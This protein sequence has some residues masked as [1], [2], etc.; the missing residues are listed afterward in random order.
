MSSQLS[1]QTIAFARPWITD[2]DREAVLEVLKRDVLTHGPEGKHFE[3]EFSAY[4]GP[5]AH[6]L[7]SSGT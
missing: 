3:E 2:S 5:N 4:V 6:S 7:S 1:A